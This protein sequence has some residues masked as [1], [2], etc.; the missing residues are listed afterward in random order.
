MVLPTMFTVAPL[1]LS[2]AVGVVNDG[3]AVQLMVVF[4]A[5]APIVGTVLSIAVMVCVT[6]AL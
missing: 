6:V 4:A 1:Q 3:V 5:A 2:D